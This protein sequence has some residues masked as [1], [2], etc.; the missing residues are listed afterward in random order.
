[1]SET[2]QTSDVSIESPRQARSGVAY[3]MIL[4]PA[5]GQKPAESPRVIGSS[6]GTTAEKVQQRLKEA[7][8]RRISLEAA[9][10]EAVKARLE[11]IDTARERR[12]E[13]ENTFKEKTSEEIERDMAEKEQRR[14]TVLQELKQQLRSRLDKVKVAQQS[15]SQ[16]FQELEKEINEKLTDA[17]EKRSARIN[18]VKERAQVFILVSIFFQFLIT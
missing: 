5:S 8:S 16:K 18:E 13:D 15:L 1:M 4:K 14:E 7:E 9:K 17:E 11:K 12:M 3:D 6:A 10:V 2:E